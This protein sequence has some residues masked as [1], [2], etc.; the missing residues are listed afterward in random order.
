[1]TAGRRVLGLE[2]FTSAHDR[3]SSHGRSRII[4]QSY[5]EGPQYVPLLLRAYELWRELELDAGERL[6]LATGGAFFGPP[7][8]PEVQGAEAA[9]REAGVP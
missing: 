7:G 5:I 6:L 3:G 8:Q 4:R 1:V 9:L 2:Q